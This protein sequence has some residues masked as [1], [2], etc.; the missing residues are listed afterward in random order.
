MEIQSSKVNLEGKG[1]EGET[2]VVQSEE[3]KSGR[4]DIFCKMKKKE[5]EHEL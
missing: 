5:Y 1:R 3:T 4:V 2:A